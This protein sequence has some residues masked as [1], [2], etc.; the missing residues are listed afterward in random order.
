MGK[1]S[2]LIKKTRGA[3]YFFLLPSQRTKFERE[4]RKLGMFG[5]IVASAVI[6]VEA[7]VAAVIVVVIVENVVFV[8]LVFITIRFPEIRCVKSTGATSHT[9]GCSTR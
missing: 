6:V 1:C 3:F 9:R 5:D 2:C 8:C 7:V 4:E